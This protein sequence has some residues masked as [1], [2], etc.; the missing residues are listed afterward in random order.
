MGVPGRSN[1]HIHHQ[2]PTIERVNEAIVNKRTIVF[3]KPDEVLQSLGKH[4]SEQ[5]GLLNEERKSNGCHIEE[6]EPPTVGIKDGAVR[7]EM[8]E[9]KRKSVQ[10]RKR[11]VVTVEK[12]QVES[13]KVHNEVKGGKSHAPL[14]IRRA[15]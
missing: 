10:E 15:H 2:P 1:V 14:T 13:H 5:Q 12:E 7:I 4:Q 11:K 8:Q 3:L 9:R 6:E